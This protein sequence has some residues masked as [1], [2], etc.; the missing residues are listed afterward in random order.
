[1]A[2]SPSDGRPV[3]AAASLSTPPTDTAPV[4]EA[5]RQLTDA[6]AARVT[7]LSAIRGIALMARDDAARA[8]DRNTATLE[9]MNDIEGR[10]TSHESR[11]ESLFSV[12]DRCVASVVTFGAM[13][14]HI[15]ER[16]EVI[17]RRLGHPSPHE[18]PPGMNDSPAGV[19][20]GRASPP[21]RR[22]RSA[23][24]PH[25]HSHPHHRIPRYPSA[26]AQGTFAML[27]SQTNA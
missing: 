2:S 15:V 24:R 3:K 20:E 26:P 1:M 10:Q 17:E 11:I 13:M 5:F 12:V 8:L 25:H 4:P 27:P 19:A 18:L 22:S 23:R 16:V 9:A 6:V 14:Q 21:A 7:E